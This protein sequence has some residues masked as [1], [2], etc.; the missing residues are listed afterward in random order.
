MASGRASGLVAII[1]KPRVIR[2]EIPWDPSSFLA[3]IHVP[4]FGSD[5]FSVRYRTVPIMLYLAM[6]STTTDSK[7]KL[8]IIIG[9][10]CNSYFFYWRTSDRTPN[11][12]G[13]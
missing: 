4:I 8:R 12:H 5:R 11:T 6:P 1:A 3:S 10:N 7:L 13:L 2:R 9:G